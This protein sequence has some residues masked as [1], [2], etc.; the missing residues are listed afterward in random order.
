M[1]EAELTLLRETLVATHGDKNLAAKILG[2]ATRTVYRKLSALDP[3]DEEP[4]HKPPDES[5]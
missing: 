4:D 1:E 2:V 5:G 3:H